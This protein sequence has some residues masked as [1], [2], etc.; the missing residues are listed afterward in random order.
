ML[1]ADDLPPEKLAPLL[2]EV[3]EY[4]SKN[5]PT[6]RDLRLASG[7]VRHHQSGAGRRARGTFLS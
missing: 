7:T 3:R 4:V 6:A 1:A 5:S 2:D